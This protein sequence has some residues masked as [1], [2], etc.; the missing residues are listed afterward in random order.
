MS[1]P[2]QWRI[3][4]GDG[5]TFGSED[6]DPA[7]AP[8]RNVQVVMQRTPAKHRMMIRKADF[9]WFVDEWYSGDLFGLF[10]Y[11]IEPGFK[12][13]KFGRTIA[14]QD[15]ETILRRARADFAL[16]EQTWER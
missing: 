16:P 5:S 9:Y 2:L 3:Y 10:D 8:T 6:G 7:K 14:T 11:L 4:Y 15:F 1:E 12:V 13:V